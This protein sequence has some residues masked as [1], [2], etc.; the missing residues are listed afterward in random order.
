MTLVVRDE[1]D[2]VGAQIAYHLNA[3]VDFVIV[4]DHES[5]DGTS[6]ILE[7]YA[8]RGV[9]RLIHERGPMTEAAWRTRMARLAATEHGADWIINTDAD[10]FWLP[11]RGTLKQTFAAIPERYGIVWG[12]TRPFV[13]R[14]DDGRSFAERMTVRLSALAP[15]NDPRA[16]TAR[17]P[18][19]PTAATRR[20]S[21]ATAPTWRTRLRSSRSGTGI[22]PMSS[23]FPSGAR[24][25]TSVRASAARTA[26][27]RWASTSAPTTRMRKPGSAG[28]TASSSWTTTSSSG[29]RA[30][31]R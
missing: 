1:V 18:R 7:S 30:M 25:S 31:A 17:T 23:T 24:R 13:P 11:R 10:E 20:S 16:R 14:P 15:I 26:T 28:C 19:S 8:H 3:G 4:T 5:Q 6:E 9:L 12:L 21:S 27:S 2:I 22:P 29:A